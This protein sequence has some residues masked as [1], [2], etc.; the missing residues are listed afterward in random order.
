MFCLALGFNSG[1]LPLKCSSK[2]E[3]K[4][5]KLSGTQI[6]TQRFSSKSG[7]QTLPSMPGHSGRSFRCPCHQ[8]ISWCTPKC[9]LKRLQGGKQAGALVFYN[10]KTQRRKELEERN[11]WGQTCQRLMYFPSLAVGRKQDWSKSGNFLTPG[12]DSS[13]FDIMRFVYSYLSLVFFT[14]AKWTRGDFKFLTIWP[15]DIL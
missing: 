3:K 11:P 8:P 4:T 10:G 13:W 7:K 12:S 15:S 1:H 14:A 5:P 2:S 6:T 9:C